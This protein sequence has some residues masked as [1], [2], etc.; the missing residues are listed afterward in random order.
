MEVDTVAVPPGDNPFLPCYSGER[1]AGLDPSALIE[2]MRGDEDCVPRAVIDACAAR[3]DEMAEALQVLADR[4]WIEGDEPG[5]WWL[6]LHAVMVLGMIAT[7]RA[8]LLLVHYMRR[9]AEVDDFDLQD[10]LSGSWPALFANKPE[11]V[12]PAL[13]DLCGDRTLN[14]YIRANA[15]DPIVA[16]SGRR[17]SKSLDEALAWLANV[18]ADEE[19]DWDFRLSCG[20]VLIDFPREPHRGLLEGLAARQT[21]FGV[22]FSATEIAQAYSD[23]EDL[24]DWRNRDDPWK[25]YSP[26]AI[27]ERQER[28]AKEDAKRDG[29]DDDDFEDD[30]LDGID[31]P[32]D[33]SP[34]TFVR[35]APKLGRNDPCPCGSGKKYKK[36]C[37]LGTEGNSG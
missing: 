8:G 12:L 18:A 15:V 19:E 9:M 36:C 32:F 4:P 5:D 22:D 30:Y 37:L 11:A 33:T 35:A 6:H 26:E 20:S 24:P 29:A 31:S 21:G 3:G 16:A 34:M 13:R 23:L 1:L 2:L 10:W 27:V 17:G 7:D 14:W 25:F 28:R